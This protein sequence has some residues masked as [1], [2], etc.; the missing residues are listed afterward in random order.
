MALEGVE[1]LSK[2]N[3]EDGSGAVLA[4]FFRISISTPAISHSERWP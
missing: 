2:N 4:I 3:R 1:V